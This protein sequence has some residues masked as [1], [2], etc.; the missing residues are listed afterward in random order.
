MA[1]HTTTGLQVF[2]ADDQDDAERSDDAV[3]R[4]GASVRDR[5]DRFADGWA[6]EPGQVI[7]DAVRFSRR[8]GGWSPPRW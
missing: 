7:T 1:S 5:A 2:W 3:S 4:L 6:D 8:G